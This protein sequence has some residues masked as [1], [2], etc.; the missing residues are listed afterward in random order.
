MQFASPVIDMCSYECI[1]YFI[2]Q[3]NILCLDFKLCMLLKESGYFRTEEGVNIGT[4]ADLFAE[5]VLYLKAVG[6]EVK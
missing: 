2:I 1:I 5:R 4:F 6:K 3:N